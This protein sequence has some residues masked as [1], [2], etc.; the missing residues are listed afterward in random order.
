MRPIT[1]ILLL[2]VVAFCVYVLWPRKADVKGFVPAEL[3]DLEVQNWVAEKRD[4]GMDGLMTRYRIYNSQF[5][6]SPIASFRIAQAQGA[7]NKAVKELGN[8]GADQTMENHA[9]SILTEKYAMIARQAGLKFD[10][11]ALAREEL[12]WRSV[13]RDG[14]PLDSI[15]RSMEQPLAAIYGGAPEDYTDVAHNIAGARSLIFSPEPPVDVAD[16]VAA[17]EEITDEAYSLLKELAD[18]APPADGSTTE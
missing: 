2:L 14:G 18:T 16:P 5:H 8:E 3:A 9:L 12:A 15:A 10:S 11:D 1:K 6:F 13:E 17:A 4:K 7:A